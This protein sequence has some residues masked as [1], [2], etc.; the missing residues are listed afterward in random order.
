MTMTR[1]LALAG[2]GTAAGLGLVASLATAAEERHPAIRAAIEALERAKE[3]MEHANHDFGG[4]RAEALKECDRAIAQL[5]LAL[6]F[7]RS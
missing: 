1:R 7:D 4:H 2:V 6:Q 5:R 3:D